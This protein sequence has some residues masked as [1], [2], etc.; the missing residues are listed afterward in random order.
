MPYPTL[1]HSLRGALTHLYEP[2]KLRSSP[3]VGLLGLAQRQ[4]SVTALQNILTESIEALQPGERT[5]AN[6]GTWRIYQVLSQRF[7]EQLT[8]REV[9]TDMGLSIRQLRRE[10]AEGLQLLANHLAAHY[11]LDP[12]QQGPLLNPDLP[13]DA[14]NRREELEW[15]KCSQA[16]E[17]TDLAELVAGALRTITPLMQSLHVRSEC[18]LPQWLP[19][20]A[21]Q[22]TSM[23][24]VLVSVLMAGVRAVPN[25]CLQIEA[26]ALHGQVHL[27]I[28]PV[29]PHAPSRALDPGDVES[30][31]IA[32]DL[33]RI[34]GSDLK[35]AI[36]P[37]SREPFVAHLTL[38]AAERVTVLVVDDN[39][40][41]LKLYE[42]YL[43]GTRYRCLTAA[44]PHKA[45]AL[46][47]E[48]VPEF[49]LL[50]VMLPGVDGWE[51]LGRLREH[52]RLRGSAIIICT[53]LSQ[54]PLALTLGAAA[55]L[56]K[57]IS[58]Q[59]LLD[60]LDRQLP[61]SIPGSE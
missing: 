21:V 19:H 46:A 30:L 7:I 35:V 49:I 17:T 1:I 11:H 12:G 42:R 60:V 24:Q 53:I 57:P 47:E 56:R 2:N 6:A 13:S 14:P 23:R 40:D 45:L 3:L 59:M 9:S 34:S 28:R 58:R 18:S 4:D 29:K 51:L 43:A 55:F 26:V 22:V 20:L 61:T 8:Q 54:E 15:L 41:T 27:E 31:R 38:P 44:D 37:G 36:R 39:V 10:E 48:L 16:S 32:E 50:D 52:P 5:P 25:G 33:A